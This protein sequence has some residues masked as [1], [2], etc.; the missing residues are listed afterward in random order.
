MRGVAVLVVVLAGGC[1]GGAPTVSETTPSVVS[2]T[3]APY[4]SGVVAVSYDPALVPAGA[5]A[6]VT[7]TQAAPG[8][9]IQLAVTGLRP[10]RAYGA[11]LHQKPCGA[12]GSAAGPHYQHQ[13]DPAAS[14]SPP[15]VDPTYAN[16]ENEV[17]LDFTTDAS[18]AATS[19]AKQPWTFGASRPGSLV[20]HGEKTKTAPGHAGDAGAR[21]ACLSLP[22]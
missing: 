20:I 9:Q 21:V 7:I 13:P 22:S 6:T 15:S 14:A 4:A 8:T 5:T 3:F 12:E 1:A 18:G 19:T 2:G 16:P 10:D 11:H 17:W